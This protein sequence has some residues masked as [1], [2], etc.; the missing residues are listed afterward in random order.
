MSK[1]KAGQPRRL[2]LIDECL[3]HDSDTRGSCHSAG[4]NGCSLK[5]E[6]NLEVVGGIPLDR[7]LLE[8]DS[9]YCEIRATHAGVRH[10]KSVWPSRKKEKHDPEATVKNRNEPCHIRY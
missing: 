9:P 7:L 1:S 3:M 10:V 5:T 8:T 4:V 6:E 2:L